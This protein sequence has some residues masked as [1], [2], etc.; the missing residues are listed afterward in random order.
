M[1]L[2]DTTQHA[3]AA[4]LRGAGSRQ[5]ALADNLANVDTP[6]YRRKDVDFHDALRSA[7]TGDEDPKALDFAP[8]T[9]SSAPIRIDGNSVDI[10][11]ESAALAQNALE[12]DALAQVSISRTAILKTAMGV[13]P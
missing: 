10:D 3:L 11:S 5:K 12:Y 2:F 7:M 8:Q 6:G 4:A 1:E 13:Q 9:D